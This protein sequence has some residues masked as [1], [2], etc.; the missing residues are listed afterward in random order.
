MFGN[1]GKT[2]SGLVTLVAG[3]PLALLFGLQIAR[4]NP[5]A[6]PPGAPSGAPSAASAAPSTPSDYCVSRFL[7]PLQTLAGVLPASKPE[8]QRL[9]GKLTGEGLSANLQLELSP[10]PST[11]P[12]SWRER[13]AQAREQLLVTLRDGDKDATITPVIA[14]IPDP[15]D[16]GLG[17]QFETT[18]QALRRGAEFASTAPFIPSFYRD[19]SWLPWDDREIAAS[20]RR[21]SEECRRSM[22]G[23]MLFRGGDL[24]Q[25]RLLVLLLVG[26]SPTTGL[27]RAAMQSALD[28]YEQLDGWRT[29][30]EHEP[31]P[32]RIVGPSFSG[33]AQ[34]MRLALRSWQPERADTRL[35]FRVVSGTATGADVPHWLGGYTLGDRRT[36]SF[37]ATTVPEA[38]VQ[39]AYLR[40][41]HRRMNVSPEPSS[42]PSEPGRALAGVAT[43]SEMGT[44]FGA[45]S[46]ADTPDCRWA[47]QSR[48]HFAFHI[49]ALRDAYEDLEQREAKRDSAIARAT[50]LP[51]SLREAQPPLDIE[52]SPSQKTRTADDLALG[53]VLEHISLQRIK[54][55]AIHAT[56]V[57]DAIFLARKI[58]DVV[59]DVRLAFFESDA[60]LL[61][62]EFRQELMGSLVVS[63]Y[64]FLG[65][66]ELSS[67]SSTPRPAPD[68]LGSFAQ[69]RFHG[70]DNGNAQGTYNA[71]LAQRDVPFGLL[72][73]YSIGSKG[74]L[75]VWIAAVGRHSLVPLKV[76]ST[77]DCADTLYGSSAHGGIAQDDFDTLCH[78]SGDE[79]V[80]A[81]R[82]FSLANEERLRLA[83]SSELPYVWDLLFALLCVAFV[84]DVTRQNAGARRIDWVTFPARATAG[85][86]QALD[87]AIGRTKWR[88]YRVVRCFLFLL[89]FTY[90]GLVYALSLIAREGPRLRWS[91]DDLL[92]SGLDVVLFVAAVLVVASAFA[93][94]AYYTALAAWRFALDYRA[95]GAWLDARLIPRRWQHL[96]EAFHV[97]PTA[98]SPASSD[99]ITTPMPIS[100]GPPSLPP[101]SAAVAERLTIG[102]GALRS[103]DRSDAGLLSF[104]QLRLLTTMST[105]LAAMFGALLVADSFVAADVVDSFYTLH[106]DPRLPLTVMRSAALTSGVS[107]ATPAL[108]CMACV[109]VWAVGRMARLALAHS[110]SR[111]SPPDGDEDLVS[112]PIRTVLHP[113]YTRHR[114]SDAGF[115]EVER[116]LLN[117]IWRPITGRYYPA[118]ALGLA[119]V[120]L[121]LFSLKPPS[122]LESRWGTMFLAGGLALSVFLIGI[123]IVQLMQ[124]WTAL[125]KLLRRV[126][127]HPIGSAFRGVPAFAQDSV[128]HQLSRSPDEALRWSACAVMFCDLMRSAGTT[129]R[130]ALLEA[131]RDALDGNATELARLR[132]RALGGPSPQQQ[133]L[134]PQVE[135]V[136]LDA[137]LAEGVIV[138]AGDMTR[139]LERAWHES[140]LVQSRQVSVT[141]P[142][143]LPVQ[144]AGGSRVASVPA[145]PSSPPSSEP[146]SG[147]QVSAT[148]PA[149]DAAPPSAK[150]D[151]KKAEIVDALTPAASSFPGKQLPW[152]RAGQS[153]VAT[154]T[155]LL[156]HRHVRQFRYFLHVTTLCALLLVLAIA[157][158]PFQPYR[159]LLTFMWIVMASVVG[160]SLW[161]F[162]QMDRNTWMSHVSGTTPDTVTF[163][164]AFALRLLAW[165]VVPLLSVAAAQY[166][167][168]SNVLFR[169]LEPFT[170]ALQ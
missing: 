9:T 79:R 153:F 150:S 165:A 164:A 87:R 37:S 151:D 17:Y 78:G 99:A 155:T 154:V 57:G 33:S 16:S 88:F 152:L 131:H 50:S 105:L 125:R 159:L 93:A 64:P 116:H 12:V 70:F 39:C 134:H 61:H 65:L 71:L 36:I 124:Y 75:P 106:V 137:K 19:R 160:V 51:V 84:I 128:D 94:S 120:P 136:K 147:P 83:A 145:P 85:S 10:A 157:S 123:T 67:D 117:T 77:P 27:R 23:I 122:T 2:T 115:T 1:R 55:V 132:A 24:A 4:G 34:S 15:V 156:I 3:A 20:E 96:R 149:N 60:L 141:Q 47:P 169:L 102:M 148:P 7:G 168:L 112:T 81:R 95:F 143:A 29:A 103:A 91:A 86:D 166:P 138:A 66:S 31:H 127:E 108:L 82:K 74:P 46:G 140:A 170:R 43:L 13:V 63:P 98:E 139:L 107:P 62:P 42:A 104:A 110:I 76:G 6:P 163:D 101:P 8:T 97:S 14:T 59:P 144:A 35:D 129:G 80:E 48:F 32:V 21:A 69:R 92:S 26:E 162:I 142:T 45:T 38:I 53:G 72:S 56:D 30:A 100:E 109:Y 114:D 40:F 5:P 73:D 90:M 130:F 113:N 89:A 25:P 58:R 133:E 161:V 135:Q 49:S 119:F 121:V 111:V 28:I 146:G 11:A 18:L 167:D 54:H 22:P 158:Y 68:E 44:E 126:M 52:A 41:L 118:A